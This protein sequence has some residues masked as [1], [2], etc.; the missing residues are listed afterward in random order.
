MNGVAM[1]PNPYAAIE[2]IQYNI[3]SIHAN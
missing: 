3:F 2:A 1:T